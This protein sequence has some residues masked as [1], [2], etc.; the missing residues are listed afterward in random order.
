[1]IPAGT[2]NT[3]GYLWTSTLVGYLILFSELTFRVGKVVSRGHNMR[4]Q[5]GDPTAHAEVVAIR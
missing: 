5:K 4:V 1:M 3:V 2:S